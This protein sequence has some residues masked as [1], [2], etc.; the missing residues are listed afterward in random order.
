[1]LGQLCL[2]LSIAFTGQAQSSKQQ[3]G[4]S[5]KGNGTISGTLT[6]S[7]TSK[8]L[9]YATVALLQ[10][11]TTQAVGGTLTNEKGQFSFSGIAV[12]Q[13]DLAFSFIGYK[14][15]TIRQVAVT[16]AKPA[17]VVG[18]VKLGIS[19]AATTLKEVK[20]EALR[21]T[22][23][24]EADRMVVSIEG[25]ALAAGRT[26]YDVLSTAPGSTSTRRGAFSSTAGLASPSCSMAA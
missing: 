18:N 26:A 5:P 8:P 15:K 21:P 25:T 6:D 22:I 11:G 3:A 12:G 17:V 24:Q 7:L 2:F 23:T 9:E 20:V 13:Y 1:M 10:H 19:A 14:S 16:E 4:A